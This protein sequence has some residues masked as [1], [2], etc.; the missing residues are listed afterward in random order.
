MS[1]AE[2]TRS[3][4]IQQAADLFNQQ[5]YAGSSLS[6]IMAATGL[7]KGGIY[8]HFASKDDLALAAFDYAAQLTGQR[9]T[10]AVKQKRRAIPRLQAI[11]HTFCTAPDAMPLKGG[12]PLLN[13]A[14][15]SDDTHPA[16]RQRVQQAMDQW[17]YLIR[18]V[19]QQGILTDEI[20]PNV[21]PE[22]VATILIATL[23]GALMLTKLYGDRMYLQRAQLHLEQ[24]VKNLTISPDSG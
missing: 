13:T 15:E 2:D 12:C 23:E 5:G 16:L 10:Q 6:D 7:K 24:Y 4:I 21:D 8:N 11:I 17:R 3:K 9:Y 20:Q 14:V 19:V 22:A 18:Q 1:K